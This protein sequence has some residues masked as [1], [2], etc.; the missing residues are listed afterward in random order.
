MSCSAASGDN[1]AVSAG[2]GLAVLAAGQGR[3]LWREWICA[4]GEVPWR[5]CAPAMGERA[6]GCRVRTFEIAPATRD[7]AS[8]G[9]PVPEAAF[10]I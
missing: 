7:C 3:A 9:G 6:A 2:K 1:G 5:A 10:E 4:R 8:T